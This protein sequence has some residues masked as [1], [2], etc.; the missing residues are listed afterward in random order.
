M[1]DRG[2]GQ[3][4]D[5]SADMSPVHRHAG[6]VVW[7]AGRAA[8]HAQR[9]IQRQFVGQDLRKAHYVVLASL[10]DAGPAAQGPLA[11][12]VAVDR[13]DMVALLDDLQARGCVER[14]ADPHDRRRK[15][16]EITGPGAAALRELDALV[17]A[18]DVELLAP[19]S[20]AERTVLADLL[21]RILPAADR[22]RAGPA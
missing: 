3:R 5:Y 7:L 22:E 21:A 9:L 10:A 1:D 18:A 19:L 12:R 13:S 2:S 6:R 17:H 20:P 8:L 11:D 14:R 16:V 4:S 15:I